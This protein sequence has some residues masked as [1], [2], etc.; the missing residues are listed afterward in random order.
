MT[1]SFSLKNIL[2]LLAIILGVAAIVGVESL[3]RALEDHDQ[4]VYR[5]GSIE[6]GSGPPRQRR[7]CER[8]GRLA[9]TWANAG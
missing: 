6:P 1:L 7:R 9:P 3:A 4:I 8:P 5:I 2:P